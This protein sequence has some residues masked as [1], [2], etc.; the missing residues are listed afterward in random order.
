[1]GWA[2]V[3]SVV[4]DR[5]VGK[6]LCCTRN[7]KEKGGCCWLRSGDGVGLRRILG[8]RTPYRCW[9]CGELINMGAAKKAESERVRVRQ[10][11]VSL[12]KTADMHKG[13]QDIQPFFALLRKSAS[14]RN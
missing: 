10:G 1:V 13:K 4:V 3:V 11:R 12:I 9:H 7:G 8:G 14:G 5:G 2:E 6:E